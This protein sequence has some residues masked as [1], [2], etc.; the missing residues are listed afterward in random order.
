MSKQITI[1]LPYPPSANRLWSNGANGRKYKTT[2]YLSFESKAQL[3]I[4]GFIDKTLSGDLSVTLR[5]YRPRRT[6][7]LDNRVKATLDVMQGMIYNDDSQIVE[8]HLYRLDD[9]LNPRVE[10]N[11]CE[12]PH[13]REIVSLSGVKGRR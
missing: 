8:L 9:K 7:D 5:I 13:A 2:E 10:V 4:A 11:V 6:G 1:T 3:E 12:L